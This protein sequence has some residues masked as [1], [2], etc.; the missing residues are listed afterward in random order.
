VASAADDP[1]AFRAIDCDGK[2]VIIY[3]G[4]GSAWLMIGGELARLDAVTAMKLGGR[5]NGA[6]QRCLGAIKAARA[7][8]ERPASDG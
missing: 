5:L 8:A 6:G 7:A 1:R 4:E 2:P 3:V